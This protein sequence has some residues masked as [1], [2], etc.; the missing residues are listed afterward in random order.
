MRFTCLLLW[1][2]IGRAYGQEFEVASVKA[3]PP[4]H[5]PAVGCRGGPGTDDPGLFA[6]SNQSLRNL[7][8]LAYRIDFSQL[9][10]PDWLMD[11]GLVFDLEAR[12]PQGTTT[13]QFSIMFQN[14]LTDRF[15]LA[16]RRETKETQQYDLVVAKGG[17]KFL[18]TSALA[19]NGCPAL[20]SG[21]SMTVAHGQYV[22]HIP[23]WSME[24]FSNQLAFLLHTHVR[25][26]TGLTGN[27][28][29]A[30]CWTPENT[31]GPDSGPTL[32]QALSEQLGLRLESKKGPV[33]M[34]VL[35]HA[36]KLP[37]EN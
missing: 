1:L 17:P 4:T 34:I 32:Q 8:A 9:S 21:Q 19:K 15:K 13:A 31:T 24:V 20:P 23:N 37:T 30:M 10:A 36:E 28:D 22:L 18:G 11:S 2:A 27:F 26:A 14:L 33:E 7:V 6:C 29:I 3:S 12:V 16:I 25:D 5:G 35:E